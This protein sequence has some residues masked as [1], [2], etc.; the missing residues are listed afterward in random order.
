MGDYPPGFSLRSSEL[1]RLNGVSTIPVREAMRRLEAERLVE[2]VANKGVRVALLSASDLA[3][4]YQLRTILEVEAVR[5]AA[6]RLTSLDR[7]RAVELRAEMEQRF[8]DGDE[9]G[10]YAA[11]RALH[12]IVYERTNSPWLV[13]I[14]STLWDH[15]ERYRRLGMQWLQQPESQAAQHD[16]VI[17]ALFGGDADTAVAAL[18]AHFETSR[19]L[20]N[21]GA[22]LER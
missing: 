8:A 10:A 20:L 16:D 2:S 15:T 6:G 22:E 9:A 12:F 7:G 11:H 3:D 1:A 4:A 17:E 19:R 21:Q 13:H 5:I 18:R 14:I